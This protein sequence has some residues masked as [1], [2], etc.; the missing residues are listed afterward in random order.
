MRIS[1]TEEVFEVP[2]AESLEAFFT[3]GAGRTCEINIL[4]LVVR[5]EQKPSP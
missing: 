5:A 4:G 3:P 2:G 1:D